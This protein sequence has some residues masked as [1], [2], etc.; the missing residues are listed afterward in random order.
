[1]TPHDVP[2]RVVYLSASSG[3]GHD[4][5]ARAMTAL[6][7]AE[8]GSAL[9]Q[10]T[11]DFYGGGWLRKFPFLARIRYHS[12]VLWRVVLA[13]TDSRAVVWI[14]TTLF[15]PFALRWLRSR[16]STAPDF[17]VAV[18]FGA[19]QCVGALA[20][21]FRV[22]PR[23]AIIVTDYEAHWA[24][25]GEADV[26]VVASASAEARLREAKVADER[27]FRL[28]LLPSRAPERVEG[29]AGAPTDG[30][31]RILAIAGQDGTSASRLTEVLRH[32]DAT[33]EAASTIVEVICG[34]G[35]SLHAA[36]SKLA[37]SCKSLELNVHGFVDDVPARLA[38]A[39]L[40]LLR[41]GPQSI[42]EALL[43]GKPVI[44]F[45]WHV[46]EAA[47][48]RLLEELGCGMGSRK[49]QVAARELARLVRDPEER[50][51][52]SHRAS[53][54]AQGAPDQAFARDFFSRLARTPEPETRT[55][56]LAR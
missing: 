7:S 1:M 29:A 56:V 32:L 40:A 6:G 54:V 21:S 9:E 27:I 8:F 41:A 24:W 46:H 26:Y 20:R 34:R 33:P 14:I 18:H 2:R 42:T 55:A 45:D 25:L 39:D 12:D 30:K 23:T 13:S 43:A 16:V 36:M 17:L 38:R 4:A 31:V 15:R 52:L 53:R 10:Q 37:R 49:P 11:L 35:E 50:A 22:P 28:P 51:T 5:V 47:N 44:A 48:A 3:G 19:A